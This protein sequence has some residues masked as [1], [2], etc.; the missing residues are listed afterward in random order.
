MST[1][2]LSTSATKK[3]TSNASILFG[4]T[5]AKTLAAIETL[6][7]TKEL[8]TSRLAHVLEVLKDETRSTK[9]AASKIGAANIAQIKKLATQKSVMDVLKVLSA[10]KVPKAFA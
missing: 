5:P 7:K 3:Q 1:I 10:I 9:Y 2:T 8:D 4:K 6:V